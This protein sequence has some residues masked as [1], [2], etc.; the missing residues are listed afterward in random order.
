MRTE[1]LQRDIGVIKETFQRKVDG[2]SALIH[3]LAKDIEEAEQQYRV[4]LQ[5]H[6]VKLDEMVGFQQKRIKNL[7]QEYDKELATLRAEFDKE[8]CVCV[9]VCCRR[10]SVSIDRVPI[11]GCNDIAA[12]GR[13]EGTGGH[14]LYNGAAQQREGD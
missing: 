9:C 10:S 2:K 5:R 7:E 1:D 11:Q 14:P 12:R 13:D 4:A 3:S 8:R 6:L